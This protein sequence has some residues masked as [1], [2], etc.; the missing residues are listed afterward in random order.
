MPPGLPTQPTSPGQSGGSFHTWVTWWGYNQLKY[1][2]FR[3]R[4]A[5]RRGPVSGPG[6]PFG[7]KKEEDPNAW[8]KGVRTKYAGM[9]LEA[10]SD[11]DEEVRTAAAVALGKWRVKDAVAELKKMRVRDKVQQ[12]RESALLGLVLMRDPAL[13]DYL[14]GVAR[15][16]SELPRMRGYALLGVGMTGDKKARDYVFKLIDPGSKAER[17]RYPA[18]QKVLREILCAGVA[19]VAYRPDPA[20]GDRLMAVARNERVQEEVRAYS[21][22]AVGK[23]GAAEQLPRIVEI[24]KRDKSAQLRRSAAIALGRLGTRADADAL[25]AL[26]H[27][28]KYDRDRVVGH[29][30][31]LS[32]GQIGGP[33]AAEG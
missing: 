3:N 26:R 33:L 16:P 19:G 9:L 25:E 8:R 24:L 13:A 17:A 23:V 28:L 7:V 2:D 6:A 14:I 12:V 1:L 21:V 31:T 10:L 18:N 29:F 32:L 22:A 20:L 27:A 5:A 4:Q 11:E 15:T 30:A